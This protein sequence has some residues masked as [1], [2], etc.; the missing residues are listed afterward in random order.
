MRRGEKCLCLPPE[1]VHALACP[2]LNEEIEAAGLANAGDSRR[3]QSERLG[4]GQSCKFR[5]DRRGYPGLSSDCRF[6][7]P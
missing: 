5:I 2:I 4:I 1:I 7:W 3:Q 6:R